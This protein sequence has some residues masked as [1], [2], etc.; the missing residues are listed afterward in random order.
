MSVGRLSC[1]ARRPKGP[2]K[3]VGRTTLRLRRSRRSRPSARSAHQ[4]TA[5][6]ACFDSRS[7]DRPGEAPSSQARRNVRRRSSGQSSVQIGVSGPRAERCPTRLLTQASAGEA[8]P[9]AVKH[10]PR[11]RAPKQDR[12]T[13]P[14]LCRLWAWPVPQIMLPRS[15]TPDAERLH[16]FSQSGG[17]TRPEHPSVPGH[18]HLTRGY[19]F[20]PLA[21]QA[22]AGQRGEPDDESADDRKGLPPSFSRNRHCGQAKRGMVA[23]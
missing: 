12:S 23:R 15:P 8:P 16:R 14:P 18:T 3:K 4:E 13:T 10:P 21:R 1:P 7:D 19:G 5:D 17:L 22:Q 2:G 11:A 20:D 9:R 6:G